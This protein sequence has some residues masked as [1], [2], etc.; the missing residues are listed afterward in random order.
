MEFALGIQFQ[1]RFMPIFGLLA[2][3]EAVL[4]ETFHQKL[5]ENAKLKTA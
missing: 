5:I 3:G 4:P 1:Y 2:G